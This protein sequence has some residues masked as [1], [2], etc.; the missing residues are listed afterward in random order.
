[1]I[2]RQPKPV[3]VHCDGPSKDG[4]PALSW[5]SAVYDR[6][7]VAAYTL[8]LRVVGDPALAERAVELAFSEIA[9][10]TPTSVAVEAIEP[11]IQAAVC[12][13]ALAALRSGATR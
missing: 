8:S 3:E 2:R 4:D 6:H 11:T 7:S 5:L 13:F 12:R 1:M 10:V 9:R